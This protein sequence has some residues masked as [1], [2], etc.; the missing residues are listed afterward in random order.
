M[1]GREPAL[2]VRDQGRSRRWRRVAPVQQRMHLHVRDAL[3]RGEGGDGHEVAVVGVD[4][5][6]P[7]EADRG[8]GGRPAGPR[9]GR[10]RASAGVRSKVP[11]YSAASIRWRSGST[12]RPAPR[13]RWPTSELP[14]WPGGRPTASSEAPRTACGHAA[15]RPRQVGIL[16]AAIASADGS[17]PIPNPSSTM[18]T[19][20]RGRGPGDVTPPRSRRRSV[21]P[22]RS[23]RPGPRSRPSRR[24]GARRR[25]PAPRRAMARRTARRRWPT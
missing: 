18:S 20:G 3:P 9:A 15:S 14:I 24:A 7:D 22:S 11:S 6:R 17:R 2:E 21:G 13:L 1:R 5:A 4:A 8:G 19:I 12:G 16:A 10:R 23:L 25:R